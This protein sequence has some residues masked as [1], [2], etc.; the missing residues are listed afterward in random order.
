MST[1]EARPSFE[2]RIV[3]NVS[4]QDY[5]HHNGSSG[6]WIVPAKVEGEK[7]GM[8]VIYNAREIQDTG[9]EKTV[10][11]WPKAGTVAQDVMQKKSD[12]SAHV[13]GQRGGVEKWGIL[14]CAATPDIP[15]ELLAAIDE[16]A[17]YLQKNPTKNIQYRDPES[18]LMLAR[19][20]DHPDIAAKKQELSDTVV[21]LREKFHAD[22]RKMVTKEEIATGLKNMQ[23]EDARLVAEGDTLWAGNELAKKNISELHKNACRRLGQQ[24]PWCYIPEALIDCPG[25]GAKI[26][27]DIVTCPACGGDL[28]EGVEELRAMSLKNRAKKM[29]PERY[30]E[31]ATR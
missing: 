13:L 20:D 1:F 9:D 14:L 30:Q 3:I 6:V 12:A 24:R 16:E 26:K 22:C 4:D 11:H 29:Y 8:L 21:A 17:A 19:T 23:K 27:D 5:M 15:R 31:P 7:F 10:V 25:C 18:K 28:V 2:A